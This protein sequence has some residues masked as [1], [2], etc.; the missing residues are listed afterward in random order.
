MKIFM[1]DEDYIEIPCEGLERLYHHCY[2]FGIVHCGKGVCR[3]WID[4]V[5]ENEE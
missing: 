5:T 4:K 3:H 1:D 2:Y